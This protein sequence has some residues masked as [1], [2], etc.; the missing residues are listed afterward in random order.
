MLTQMFLEPIFKFITML[1]SKIDTAPLDFTSFESSCQSLIKFLSGIFYFIPYD[2]FFYC[3]NLL[4][5][6]LQISFALS[7]LGFIKSY[8]PV[9]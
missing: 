8:I 3:L 2:A 4:L 6:Y 1:I 5:I 9:A 7:I